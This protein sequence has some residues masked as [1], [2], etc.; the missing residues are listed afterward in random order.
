[1]IHTEWRATETAYKHIKSI[2][3]S[4]VGFGKHTSVW[5]SFVSAAFDQAPVK[6]FLDGGSL[7]S[8]LCHLTT[9]KE[10]SA[11]RETWLFHLFLKYS[12]Q[13]VSYDPKRSD[14]DFYFSN[15]TLIYY[16]LVLQ[17]WATGLHIRL[18]IWT[19]RIPKLLDHIYKSFHFTK[20]CL[21]WLITH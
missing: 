12:L 9:V 16:S 18:W 1:M 19:C 15:P 2:L 3:E 8:H 17:M 13:N 5:I 7:R 10:N 6:K 20:L 11:P 14:A 21:H 4:N